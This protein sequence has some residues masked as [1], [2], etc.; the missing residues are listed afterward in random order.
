MN[1]QAWMANDG[2]CVS[3][4]SSSS[5]DA[6]VEPVRS[7]DSNARRLSRSS[8]TLSTDG[9]WRGGRRVVD[10][11]ASLM[12]L[13]GSFVQTVTERH[14]VAASQPA[15][16]KPVTKYKPAADEARVEELREIFGTIDKDNSGKIDLDELGRLLP[17]IG[18]TGVSDEKIAALLKEIDMNGDD[19]VDFDEFLHFYDVLMLGEE[20][21]DL[22]GIG[23]RN[24]LKSVISSIAQDDIVQV[25]KD[26]KIAVNAGKDMTERQVAARQRIQELLYDLPS[27]APD[28]VYR[29]WW[30]VVV[31]CVLLYIWIVPSLQIVMSIEPSK[32]LVM[33]DVVVSAILFLDILV[34]LNTAVQLQKGQFTLIVDRSQIVRYHLRSGGLLL[35]VVASLP[36]DLTVWFLTASMLWWRVLRGLRLLK[37]FRLGGLFKMTDRGSMDPAFVR[38]FFWTT[39]LLRQAF[40]IVAA[41]HL[42]TLLR[43]VVTMRMS[44]PAQCPQFGEEVCTDD[45]ALKYFYAFFWVWALLT[46]QGMAALENELSYAYAA[47]VM[48][49]SLVLQ[50]HVVANMS[51][52]VLKSNVEVQ[53]QD[54]MRSTLAI[55]S[56]YNI[57]ASLQQEVLSFQYHSLQQ[58]AAASLAHILER[59]PGPMQREVGLYVKVGLVTQ[60]PMFGDLSSD[61]RLALA[62][63]L[64]QTYAGPQDYIIKYGEEG[65]EMFFMMHGFADVM[66]P[67]VKRSEDGG[68]ADAL[69]GRVV[70]TIKRGDFF[71]EVALL[72][73]DQKRTA[74]IQALTYCDLFRLHNDDFQPIYSAYAELSHRMEA[75]ARGRGLV[76][77]R[78][79]GE[80]TQTEVP[81]EEDVRAIGSKEQLLRTSSQ[82]KVMQGDE[83]RRRSGSTGED[84]LMD[85]LRDLVD[86]ATA[87]A[88]VAED[89]E[90]TSPVSSGSRQSKAQT[91]IAP[92]LSKLEDGFSQHVSQ[93]EEGAR[94]LLQD[95]ARGLGSILD[96]MHTH[97]RESLESLERVLR[98]DEHVFGGLFG[99][100]RRTSGAPRW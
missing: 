21:R 47:V 44:E 92:L 9:H 40:T 78:A 48:L 97:V 77:R 12:G 16:E 13:G 98:K 85:D 58:N 1:Q 7:T 74:S 61:C 49:M 10:V 59:L 95:E 5:Q 29:R 11:R 75:E 26:R 31:L 2:D 52:L 84:D 6:R 37:L 82:L 99:G 71:G 15:A 25:F 51:A 20:H 57:P 38:F 72:E 88:A 73:P 33:V 30:D 14:R 42:L 41:L 94:K 43:L 54:A 80:L 35:D 56:H 32:K 55:M 17:E 50:G 69:E 86:D 23:V 64:E 76:R 65:A 19:A 87:R 8:S 96:E 93:H 53:N 24:R 46:T 67:A 3:T 90:M 89:L 36:L 27:F 66:V 22:H 18:V 68:G 100:Q 81:E 34:V 39:T 60:V 63:C 91:D 28:Y 62:N 70:A 4:G 79:S 83:H 45:M